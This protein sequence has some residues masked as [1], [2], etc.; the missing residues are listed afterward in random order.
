MTDDLVEE[1]L[2]R[3]T[4][5][6]RRIT[7]KVLQLILLAEDRKIYAK[8]GYSSMHKWLVSRFKY[9]E[10]AAYRRIQAARL[11]RAVPEVEE[12]IGEGS[13]NLST[14]SL[15]QSAI[16]RQEK[17]SG[18]RLSD[19]KK[20]KIVRNIESKSAAR[21]EL[22]LIELLPEAG[23]QVEQ[24][25][26]T[27]VNAETARVAAN[28]P[29]EVLNDIER[30][31]DM[32]SHTLPGASFVEVV[33][34]LAKFYLKKNSAPEKQR[35]ERSCVYQDPKTGKV[36]GSTYMTE[37]DH[38]QPRAL[39]GSDEPE[40]RRPLCRTHNQLMAEEK[41]GSQKAN[42]WRLGRLAEER[43]ADFLKSMSPIS[44]FLIQQIS[45]PSHLD[46]LNATF[47]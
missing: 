43:V 33:G 42:E 20:A 32:L 41:L 45:T 27:V 34:Y 1:K 9:S 17:A 14:L 29:V 18:E 39:G 10:A 12:K 2:D 22:A 3:V 16:G 8:R 19:E 31:K 38:I 28:F 7:Q 24:E 26:K 25:K 5:F 30:I 6:E 35:S 47:W 23:R 15:A 40:N 46:D 4:R 44:D 13:V 11:L 37:S 36:C 21:A